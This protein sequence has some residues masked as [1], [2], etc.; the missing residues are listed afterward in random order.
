MLCVQRS[1]T[2]LDA[3]SLATRRSSEM[4]NND[5]KG[6]ERRNFLQAIAAATLAPGNVHSEPAADALAQA[7]G[8]ASE[9]AT[10]ADI[11]V[12]NLVQWDVSHVFGMVGDGIN[13][14]ID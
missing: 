5:P 13:P 1:E 6:V 9:D 4:S 14:L 2:Y 12:E 8:S 10:A 7:S 11:I 3:E